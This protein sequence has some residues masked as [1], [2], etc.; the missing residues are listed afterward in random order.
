[1]KILNSILISMLCL[2]VQSSVAATTDGI[3]PFEKIQREDIVIVADLSTDKIKKLKDSGKIMPLEEI[4]Q[5]VKK[6]YPGRIIEIE[7]D[8][9]DGR[10]IYELEFVG[11]NNIVWELEVDATSGDVLKYEQ[12]D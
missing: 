4:I 10:Y 3:S 5:K 12:D 1:M 11:K 2:T 8:N 9:E 7:L 6:H